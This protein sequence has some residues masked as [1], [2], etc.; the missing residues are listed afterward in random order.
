[1]VDLGVRGKI[2]MQMVKKGGKE[3]GITTGLSPG[4]KLHVY[5][6]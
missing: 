3:N 5:S 2:Q 4:K 1:M 6:P